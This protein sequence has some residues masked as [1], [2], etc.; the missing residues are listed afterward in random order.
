MTEPRLIATVP[1]N[2]IEEVRVALTE[3]NGHALIDLRVY[4]DF[5]GSAGGKRPTKK[6]IS[7][8]RERL[9]DLIKALQAAQRE[10]SQ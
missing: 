7:L 8:A 3:F 2:A 6:G 4:A 1:K 10:A 5:D 9:P